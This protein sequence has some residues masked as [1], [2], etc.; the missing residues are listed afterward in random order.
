MKKSYKVL[1]KAI[2]NVGTKAVA[3]KLKVS[4]TLVYK[5]CQEK[6]EKDG[7]IASGAANPLDRIRMIYEATDDIELINWICQIADGYYVKNPSKDKV[8]SDARVMKNIHKFIRE[9]SETLDAI[10]DSYADKSITTDE[11]K[12]IRKEWEDLKRIGE[13]FVKACEMGKFDKSK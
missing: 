1:K 11:A 2:D 5:W 6:E 9:F 12:K 3:A 4:N 8:T 7:P 10:S 13:G